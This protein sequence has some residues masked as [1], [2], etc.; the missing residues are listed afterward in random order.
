MIIQNKATFFE[1]A[2]TSQTSKIYKN[3]HA[4]VLD[5]QVDGDFTAATVVVEG[6]LTPA[7]DWVRLAGINLSDFSVAANG[8][9]KAGIYEFSVLGTREIRARVDNINGKVSVF[10]YFISSEEV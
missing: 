6:R 1:E 7:N 3:S 5:L 8:L 10:G 4:D 2:V 9:T